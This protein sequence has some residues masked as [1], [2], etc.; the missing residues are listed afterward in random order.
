VAN[1]LSDTV[2]VID[3][4]TE[5]VSATVNVGN[6]PVGIAITPNGKTVYVDN[7]NDDTV[8]PIT[9]LTNTAGTP[10]AVGNTPVGIA[11]NNAGTT[12]YVTNQF[13]NNIT[14]I[15]VSTNT[16]GTPFAAGGNPE[17][18]ALSP[19]GTTAWVTDGS[20]AS[21]LPINLPADTEGTPVSVGSAP[22][23]VAIT[24]DQGPQA[25][26]SVTP[27]PTLS[28]TAFDASASVAPSTPITSYAWNFGDGH[29]ATT[30]TPMTTHTYTSGGTFTAT[31]TETDADGT[32]TTQVFTGATVTLN[33]SAAA[34]GSDTFTIVDCAANSSCSASVSTPVQTVSV[35]GVSTTTTSVTL[36][37]TVTSLGCGTKYDYPV[38]VSTLEESNFNSASG[39]A[40]TVTQANE[41]SKKGAKICYQPAVPSPPPP[42]LLGK[43]ARGSP[44]PPCYTS[45]TE[46]GGSV[47]A[48]FTV[49]AGDPRFWLGL[50]NM[51]LKKF[52]PKSAAPLASVTIKG[53]NLSQVTAVTFGSTQAEI[54]TTDPTKLVVT[55]PENAQSGAVRVTG[56]SGTLTSS[57]SFRVT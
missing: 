57:K 12:A 24:P 19:D 14:P 16:P 18:I 51:T 21:L 35:S 17:G 36:S 4:A 10:I 53:T 55:V 48:T 30:S 52:T 3:T 11:I 39:I 8:T 47:V 6:T 45:I 32:S 7:E 34:V 44:V 38:T 46:S 28:P 15:T 33:G 50:A 40:V 20:P 9:T 49:P 1:A 31:V 37:D 29:T 13:S 5:S 23:A 22:S 54:T 42:V 25:Q 27:A 56:V 2:S 43:C 41:K 26:L